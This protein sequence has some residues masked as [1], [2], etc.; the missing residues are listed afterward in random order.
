MSLK[1]RP[2]PHA[3][4][5]DESARYREFALA[6]QV[7]GHAIYMTDPSGVISYVNPEFERATGFSPAEAMGQTPRI[8]KSGLMSDDYYRD[9]WRAILN[10]DTWSEEVINRRKNGSVYYALQTIAS[11]KHES[12]A[13]KSFVALQSDVTHEGTGVGAG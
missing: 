12:G 7:A 11:I 5:E 3:S 2:E 4:C 9:L 13:I 6:V 8:L 10:G 1:S